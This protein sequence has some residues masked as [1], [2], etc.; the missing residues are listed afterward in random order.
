MKTINFINP[1]PPERRKEL[2]RWGLFSA[3]MVV[4]SIMGMVIINTMQWRLHRDLSR[5]S[6]QLQEITHNFNTVMEAQRKTK[7]DYDGLQKKFSK[8]TSCVDCPKNP[9]DLITIIRNAT[10]AAPLQSLAI[11][12]KN[13]EIQVTC[14]HAK[15]ATAM[16]KSLSQSGLF[17]NVQLASLNASPGN[18]LTAT[19]KATRAKHVHAPATASVLTA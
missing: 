14:A 13:V 16:V 11:T 3:T 15:Q 4:S 9:A 19:I 1:I 7:Q 8:L 6:Q 12:K 18:S 5:Q 2:R 10:T 17:S